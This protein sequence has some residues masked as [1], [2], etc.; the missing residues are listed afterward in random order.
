MKHSN[1]DQNETIQLSRL[2]EDMY[3]LFYESE[4]FEFIGTKEDVIA[5]LGEH[6]ELK[7]Y[8]N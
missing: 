4:N 5:E 1:Y 6:M 3:R 8:G 2:G 7:N